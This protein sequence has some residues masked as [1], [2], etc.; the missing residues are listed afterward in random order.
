MTKS[1][2]NNFKN[3]GHTA[4]VEPRGLFFNKS[5]CLAPALDVVK[6][7]IAEEMT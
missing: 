5:S 4:K 2:R 3:F 6:F 7:Q 1:K